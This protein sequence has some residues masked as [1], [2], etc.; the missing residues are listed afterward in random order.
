MKHGVLILKLILTKEKMLVKE[1]L[2]KRITL[3]INHYIVAICSVSVCKSDL[4]HYY[5][6]CLYLDL[7]LNSF[8]D[9]VH[10]VK[11]LTRVQIPKTSVV[12]L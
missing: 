2:M 10:L 11:T 5:I 12:S 9:L 6:T 4:N 1:R 8:L 3:N 7:Y